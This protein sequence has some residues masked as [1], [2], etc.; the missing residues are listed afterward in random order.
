M[1]EFFNSDVNSRNYLK[2]LFSNP[3]T[4]NGNHIY[5][6]DYE[7]N[8]VFGNIISMDSLIDIVKDGA[9]KYE[10]TYDDKAIVC[11]I[12]DGETTIIGDD[13]GNI[14]NTYGVIV[15]TGN[16]IVRKSFTGCIIAKGNIYIEG[17][18]DEITVNSYKDL[19]EELLED[20][21]C[22]LSGIL[23][24]DKPAI[25]SKYSVENMTY[26]DFVNFVNWRKTE[27]TTEESSEEI[28]TQ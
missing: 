23:N 19:V 6:Y 3:V 2:N 11:Y 16:V 4:I 27:N 20:S 13:D 7:Q 15:T 18:T 8:D 5:I 28:T 12:T 9:Y 17:D 22:D 14:K 1:P 21:D 24:T 10:T 26:K 25:N